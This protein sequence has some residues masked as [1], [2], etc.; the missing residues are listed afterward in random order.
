MAPRP[1]NIRTVSAAPPDRR[2][3]TDRFTCNHLP[4]P[5]DSPPRATVPRVRPR[6][7]RGTDAEA[8]LAAAVWQAANE[9][10]GLLPSPRRV[11]RVREKLDDPSALLLVAA[12]GPEVIGML[13]AEQG[14]SDDTRAPVP[15]L[16]H[17]SMLFVRPDHWQRGIGG[18]PFDRADR[19]CATPRLAPILTLDPGDERPGAAL[20]RKERVQPHWGEQA[21]TWR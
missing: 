14:R 11:A 16:G 20:P 6:I 3:S 5:A 21:A 19:A 8:A 18:R 13:L 9:A 2:V 7:R 15:D 1:R 4:P 17:I 10:R 12:D